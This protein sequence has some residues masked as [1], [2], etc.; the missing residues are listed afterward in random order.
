M[1]DKIN[2]LSIITN[3]LGAIREAFQ[4][5]YRKGYEDGKAGKEAANL[6]TKDGY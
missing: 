6:R 4:I 2:M 1:H 3:P 5:G